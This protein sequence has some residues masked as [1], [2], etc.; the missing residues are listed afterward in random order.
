MCGEGGWSYLGRSVPCPLAGTE[1][2][3]RAVTTVQKSAEGAAQQSRKAT[4]ARTVEGLQGREII[5]AMRRNS[6]LKSA[7]GERN[8]GETRSGGCKEIEVCVARADTERPEVGPTTEEVLEPGNLRKVPGRIEIT[9]DEIIV[10]LGR[11]TR[12]PLPMAAADY[13]EMDEPIP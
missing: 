8:G 4:K 1:R 9:G 13:R 3:A 11:R 7:F 5:R 12:N 6:R 2:F 10:T